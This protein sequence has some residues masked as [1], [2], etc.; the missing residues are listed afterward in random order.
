M[1]IHF[2]TIGILKVKSKDLKSL[3]TLI[4]GNQRNK[5]FTEKLFS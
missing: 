1:Q 2:E 3:I 5:Q 4:Q